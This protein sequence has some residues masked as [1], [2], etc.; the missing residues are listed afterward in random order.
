MGTR[1][2]SFAWGFDAPEFRYSLFS[3]LNKKKKR[4]LQLTYLQDTAESV[5]PL[6]FVDYIL[7]ESFFALR[8]LQTIF[9]Q[10]CSKIVLIILLNN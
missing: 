3:S 5:L 4:S 10:D 8:T 6:V 1:K 2:T 9:N 7:L